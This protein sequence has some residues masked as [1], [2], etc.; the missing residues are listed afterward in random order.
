MRT[1]LTIAGS[2]PGG[3]AG[4][5]A[6]LKTFAAFGVYGVS[7]ITA[8]TVQNTQGVERVAA[9]DGDL[10]EAQI[11]ALAGDIDVHATKVGMLANAAI[12]EAVTAAIDELDLPLVVLDPV[13]MSSSG[14][15]LLDADGQGAL[16]SELLARAR[17]VTPNVAEAETLAGH[18]IASIDAARD[19]ARRIR[20][21]GPRA[22]VITGG[23]AHGFGDPA[24]VVD[25]LLDGNEFHEC[26]VSRVD[27]GPTH[28]TGCTFASAV[29]A[30]LALGAALPHAVARAQQYVAGA[31]THRLAI[32]RGR[33]VLDHFWQARPG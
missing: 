28:G 31:L 18:P 17:V 27:A 13:L 26:R 30:G 8:V 15:P 2:D 20:D 1:V 7:V 32:G 22:V 23:H 4:V 6:D 24:H 19:A 11:E 3:G 9:L 21:L 33:A 10:V 29:A 16:R 12:V 5:Q 25:L 14:G